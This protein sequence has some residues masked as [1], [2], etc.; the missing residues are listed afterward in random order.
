M[1]GG[2]P[3]GT[4][5]PLPSRVVSRLHL[6]RPPTAKRPQQARILH[7]ACLQSSRNLLFEFLQMIYIQST[8]SS[9]KPPNFRSTEEPKSQ[10]PASFLPPFAPPSR[11]AAPRRAS[12]R[13]VGFFFF[14][15]GGQVV[16]P[17]GFEELTELWAA[18]RPVVGVVWLSP[19]GW[20]CGWAG[21]GW[22]GSTEPTEVG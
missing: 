12:R 21:L 16:D 8:N 9:S 19:P 3:A 1:G 4:R 11:R 2:N 14:R 18:P 22:L 13:A 17:G 20:L 7:G 15:S 6:L 5:V 10:S